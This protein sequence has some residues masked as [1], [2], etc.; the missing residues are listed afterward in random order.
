L[1]VL[2]FN[3]TLSFE[4]DDE[5][6]GTIFA[7]ITVAAVPGV[8]GCEDEKKSPFGL[9]GVVPISSQS[10]PTSLPL[11]FNKSD[12]EGFLFPSLFLSDPTPVLPPTEC[13]SGEVE[14]S[15]NHCFTPG[16]VVG[17]FGTL[18]LCEDAGDT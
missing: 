6:D 16:K 1:F 14:K 5:D 7:G 13:F 11:F 3:E 8:L 4:S 10:V 9:I 18:P 17:S 12:N 2:S 15:F